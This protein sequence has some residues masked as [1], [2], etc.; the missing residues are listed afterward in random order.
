MYVLQIKMGYICLV[1]LSITKDTTLTRNTPTVDG[2]PIE[3]SNYTYLL[4]T[5]VLVCT[6]CFPAR[7][8]M[9]IIA[10]RRWYLLIVVH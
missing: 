6:Q 4:S 5:V 8:Y 3:I 9:V 10:V 7:L 1:P 2:L